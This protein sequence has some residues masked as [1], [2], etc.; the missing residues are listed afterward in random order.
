MDFGSEPTPGLPGTSL[1]GLVPYQGSVAMEGMASI[2]AREEARTR[3]E[4]A[5]NQGVIQGL[6][7]HVK[8]VWSNALQAKR[9]TVEPR[10]FQSVRQRRGEYDP[11]ILNEI[12]KTGGSEIYMMLSS[13]KARAAASWIRDVAMGADRNTGWPLKIEPTPIPDLPPII[14][15]SV[16]ALAT[17]EAQ[18]YE[19]LTGLQVQQ[20]DMERIV[21]YM[22]DRIISNAKRRA[23]E[24]C[25][26]M[27]IKM[28]DQL[29]EGSFK[30]A[31][32]EFIEDIVTFP[33][34]IIK[35]PIVRN[36]TKIKWVQEAQPL[37][38]PEVL[39]AAPTPQ[40]A[41]S[42]GGAAPQQAQPPSQ[43]KW[44]LKT[45]DTLTLE[46]ARVD[47]F[48][49]YPA[50]HAADV[51]DGDLI[52]RHKLSRQAINEMRGVEGYSDD[53]IE[54][55]LDEYGKG[56]LNEWLYVD[57]QKAEVEGKSVAAVAQ[58]VSGTIDALQYWGSVQGKLL[59]EW[60]MDEKAIPDPL[61]D[62]PCEVWMVGRWC[63]K[64]ML[65]PDPMGR[66][67]Y[68]KASYEEVPGTFWGNSVVDLCRDTQFQCNVAARAMANNMGIASGPQTFVNVDR[69]PPGEDITQMYPWKIWQTTS[70]PYGS[71]AAP[72]QFFQPSSIA[73]ELMQIYQFFSV[74]ADE[75]TGVPRYMTGDAAA[76][77][78]GR[79]ASGMSMMMG[80][81]GK[82]I[83]QVISNIDINVAQPLFERLY[84]YNMKYGTDDDLKG[85][86]N[87]VVCGANS[88]VAKENAQVRRNEF[89]QLCL[90][91]PL[92]NEIVGPEAIADILREVTESLDMP[93]IIPPSEIIRAK[94]YQKQMDATKQAAMQAQIANAPSEEIEVERGPMGEMIGMKIKQAMQHQPTVPMMG[95]TPGPGYGVPQQTMSQ[96]GQELQD[97]GQVTDNFSPMRM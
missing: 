52:E 20:A 9:Q 42:P 91:N 65:N 57:T 12:K 71:G 56:G 10:M 62:Y 89:L 2:N 83:K 22:K 64:A 8:E 16:A 26:R 68:Y 25:D 92:V 70:D 63:I 47:P 55:V 54:Q 6:A 97:G 36:K 35:G 81:A 87:I 48:M 78:A 76:G 29:A 40:P 72:V 27:Q 61:K 90:N 31:M 7:G 50:A 30:R 18:Q 58:N 95:I 93:D 45:E 73:G 96:P 32:S 11:E 33:S 79:T 85:D 23:G 49:F 4:A 75:H 67:P 28:E 17:Q 41:P 53:A 34:A 46:W 15:R 21:G 13:N 51:D 82:A 94:A 69:L 5:N 39:P 1:S 74:L 88:M 19:Q 86:I 24:M 84:F 66:K 60:G 59:I 38:Q 43:P 77:G 80:N 3:A 37:P 44:T 14:A